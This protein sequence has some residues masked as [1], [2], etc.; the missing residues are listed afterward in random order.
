MSIRHSWGCAPLSKGESWQQSQLP[1]VHP[2]QLLKSH[3]LNSKS[4]LF[5]GTSVETQVS[6]FSWET[7]KKKVSEIKC[8]SCHCSWPC[9]TSDS[10]P[11]HPLLCIFYFPYPWLTP[12]LS[13]CFIKRTDLNLYLDFF[14]LNQRSLCPSYT[15]GCLCGKGTF[16]GRPVFITAPWLAPVQW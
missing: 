16:S 13:Q 4:I 3:A 14:F 15:W 8:N 12:L 11:F 7:Y 2:L 6:F 5:W 1:T 9:V 10:H